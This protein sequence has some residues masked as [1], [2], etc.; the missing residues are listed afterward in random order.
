MAS[1][2]CVRWRLRYVCNS[3]FVGTLGVSLYIASDDIGKPYRADHR[4]EMDS[5]TQRYREAP[6]RAAGGIQLE[7]YIIQ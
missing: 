4:T 3:V 2:S 7:K 6:I 5:P 1:P